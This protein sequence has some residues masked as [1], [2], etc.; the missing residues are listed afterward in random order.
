MHP[1][2]LLADSQL[3]F[4]TE[5]G[6][7]FLERVRECLGGGPPVAAYVGASNSDRPEFFSI[8][9][10]A[11]EQVGIRDCRMIRSEY[12]PHDRASLLAAD[13]VLLAGGDVARGWGVMERTGMGADLVARYRSGAVL[14]GISAGAV[15]LGQKGWAEEEGEPRP[16]DT[17]GL[18]PLV[19]DA[20]DEARGWDRLRW[21]VQAPPGGLEGV[22]I[23]TGGGL[24]Y[25]PGGGLHSV[26][27]PATRFSAKGAQVQ[28]TLLAPSDD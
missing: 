20:H 25:G 16:F 21:V 28:T 3:L 9:Q 17:L 18:V 15:L 24:V 2:F 8:F 1:I 27:R 12:G 22:G 26:R 23:P 4:W 7:P 6:R 11:M 5:C 13:V 14:M 19:V 10:A